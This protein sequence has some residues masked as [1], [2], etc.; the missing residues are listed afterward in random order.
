MLTTGKRIYPWLDRS[1]RLSLFK[2][3]V[4]L[5][6][7]APCTWTLL[8][9][10][11]G[12]LGPRP[13][14]EALHQTGLWAIRFLMISLAVTPLRGVLRWPRLILIRR[15]VGVAAFSYAALH[16]TLYILD[17]AFDWR[18]VAS[19]IVF[20]FYLTIGLFALM[21]LFALAVTSTDGM[22][23]RL[24]GRRWRRL[25]Q[26]AYVIAVLALLHYF[27]QSK[28]NVDEP[29]V[30]AGLFF[31]L[32]AYRAILWIG[33]EDRRPSVSSLVGLSVI[34]GLLT[35][36]GEAVYYRLA[37]GFNPW[38]VLAA[39]LGWN[40]DRRPGWIVLVICLALTMASVIRARQS[41]NRDGSKRLVRP[42]PTNCHADGPL[43]ERH[44]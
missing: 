21:S 12:T 33:N 9:Y 28:L 14:L 29:I 44:S 34:A 16:L 19:E 37:N 26:S 18:L 43:I 30:V 31:W 32:M 15:M 1:G 3:A 35:T 20:R 23:R 27:I 7:F 42:A 10:E 41:L 36:T 40:F 11:H 5:A 2:L 6:L 4:F 22:I 39:S 38:R 8:S 24:G 25:H 13:L 17:Q